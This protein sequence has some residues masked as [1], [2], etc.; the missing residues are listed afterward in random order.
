MTRQ[1][2]E[3]EKIFANHISDTGLISRIYKTAYNSTIKLQINQFFIW[4]KD[5]SR[6]FSEENTQIASDLVKRCSASL[7]TGKNLNEIPLYTYEDG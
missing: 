3:Q 2:R 7:V 1:T 4:A 6:H 5:L